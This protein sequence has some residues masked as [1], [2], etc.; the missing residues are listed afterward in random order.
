M[1]KDK[2]KTYNKDS[3]KG[4]FLFVLA[5]GGFVLLSWFTAWSLFLSR[6]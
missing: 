5:V 2:E 3:L 4:T 6:I 1:E